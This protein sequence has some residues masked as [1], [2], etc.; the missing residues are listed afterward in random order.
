MGMKWQKRKKR[1]KKGLKKERKK[2]MTER[3]K[4]DHQREV[5][6]KMTFRQHAAAI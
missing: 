3:Q 1:T 2:R 5:R 6:Y 4:N